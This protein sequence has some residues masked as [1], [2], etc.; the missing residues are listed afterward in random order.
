[1]KFKDLQIGQTATTETLITDELIQLFAKAS[2]D[3]NPIHLDEAFAQTTAFGKRIAH[4]M[5]VASFI[6]SA[7][8]N[9]LPGHGTV[10]RTQSIKFKYPAFIG[11]TV[12]TSIEIKD[13][14]ERT[15]TITLKTKCTNQDGKI[16][17]MGEA[18]V[19]FE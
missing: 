15:H 1:M 5:L 11:D 6:S 10:Y 2:G 9:K 19:I 7:I 8:A 17:V 4:G 12:V 14:V 13:M 3:R 16:L 18:V